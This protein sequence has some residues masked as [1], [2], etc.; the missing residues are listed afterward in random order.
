MFNYVYGKLVEAYDGVAVV[1]CNG[2]GYE[3]NVSDV[4]LADIK[5]GENVK[6]LAYLQV[7]EDGI[8][9]YGFSTKTE[10][11][12]FLRL[13]SVS[14]IGCKVAQSILSGITAADLASAIYNGNVKLLTKV[15]GLGKKTAERIILELREKVEGLAQDTKAVPQTTFDKQAK[16]AISVLVSLGLS[17]QDA[18]ARIETAMQLGAQTSEE[19]INMAFRLN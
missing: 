11:S 1:D 10:K 17:Q 4:T 3:L 2:L 5:V 15:K 16:D 6:L 14:G 12:M 19:L 8:A 7:K 9:L 18:T 13:I